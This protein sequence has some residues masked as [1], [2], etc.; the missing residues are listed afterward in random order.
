[1]RTSPAHTDV[2]RRWA[3]TSMVGDGLVQVPGCRCLHHFRAADPP[4]DWTAGPFG[5]D[6]D[7]CG[8]RKGWSPRSAASSPSAPCWA[9]P[10]RP[11]GACVSTPAHN[12]LPEVSPPLSIRYRRRR[13][14]CHDRRRFAVSDAREATAPRSFARCWPQVPATALIAIPQPA[15]FRSRRRTRTR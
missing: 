15:R 5:A 9:Q 2:G 6:G 8:P 3:P 7:A 4:R 10:T 11:G 14:T 12:Y 13:L 1:M